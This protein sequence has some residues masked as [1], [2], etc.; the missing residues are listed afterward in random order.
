M[1]TRATE[2]AQLNYLYLGANSDM[3]VLSNPTYDNARMRMYRQ[4][5]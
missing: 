2:F 4:H 1:N 3:P 5:Y